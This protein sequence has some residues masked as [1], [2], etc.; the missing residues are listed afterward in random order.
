MI[1][2]IAIRT[3]LGPGDVE[4]IVRLHGDLY[5]R[6]FGFD[7]TFADYVAHPLAAF[8]REGSS[9]ERI[10]IAEEGGRIVGC[11][12]IV[13]AS[14][15]EARLRWF[16][17]DPRSRGRGLGS[18]LLQLALDFSRASGYSSV[19]LWTVGALSAAA[20]LYR[21]AGFQRVEERPGRRWGVDVVEE[22]YARELRAP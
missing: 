15:K 19:T 12:A 22:R 8:A 10:W 13:A 14:E 2:A 7:E 16:L 9:R 21:D 6:E 11:V 5:A 4:A 18:T 3:A 1:R 17:V 20:R